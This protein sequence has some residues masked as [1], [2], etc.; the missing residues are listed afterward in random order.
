MLRMLVETQG[1]DWEQY[2]PHLLFAYREVPQASTGFSPFE[3]LYGRRVLGPLGLIRESWEDEP[4]PTGVSIV[5]YVMR[6]RDKMQTLTQL[7]HDNMTQAQADQKQN[8]RER[9]YQVGRKVWVLVPIPT[10]KLQA[11]WEGP[12]VVHQ[13]LN[14]VTYVV[15]LDH[16]WGRR[17][18]FHVNML[19]AHHEREA[20]V[21][22]VCN[23]PKDG[24]EDPLLDMLA[25][26][27]ANGSIED[28]EISGLLTISQRSQ[29]VETLEPFRAV[30]N[31]PGRTELAV[32]EVDTGNH[33]P[34]QRTPYRISEEVQQVMR[35]E[36]DE[37][38][39]LGVI[40][41]SKSAWASPVVLVPKKDR[42]TRFCVDYRG[43]NAITTS[44]A[45]PMPR[46]EDLLERLAKARYISIMDLSQGYWQIPLRRRRNLP[47]SPPLDCTSRQSCP[48]A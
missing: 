24:E 18:A 14:P 21:L 39:R 9:T 28:M 20:C 25:Q 43:L 32:H 2:L 33:A 29:L 26:A 7:V 1:R 37:M 6:F 19:K 11:A 12:Y 36:I 13:Q 44:D 46:I 45:H 31:R 23:L 22:P 34:L 38:L 10:D 15:T 35:Q 4:N 27:K 17:K 3:V 47:L 40:R 42:T 5:D 8:A 41:R 30:F 48:S 16:A